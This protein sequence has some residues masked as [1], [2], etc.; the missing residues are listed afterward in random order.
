MLNRRYALIAGAAIGLPAYSQVVD[1]SDAINKAGRQRML[2]QRMGKCWFATLMQVESPQI[3]SIMDRSMALFDRQLVELKAFASNNELRATYAELEQAWSEYKGALVGQ[4]PAKANAQR[5]IELGSRVLSL[6]N[7]GTGQYEALA[8][9][10]TGKLVNMAGRQ[11]M[12]SQ[13]MAKY[14]LAASLPVQSELARSEVSK[15]RTEFLSAMQTLKN[16]PEA[17]AK[18]K[19][20]ITLAETQW[21]FFNQ[22]L[23]R[24]ESNQAN[25]KNHS[26]VFATSET[27]LVTMDRVTGFYAAQ[28][29]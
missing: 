14:Y 16:A 10:P 6:A 12:L 11:R 20:E 15:A 21:V 5:V 8:T 24:L 13:R 26:D 17:T 2:S 9:R 29:A 18:I 27:I 4:T 7:K 3:S 1:L 25:A 19:E 28:S 22:S 23:Q